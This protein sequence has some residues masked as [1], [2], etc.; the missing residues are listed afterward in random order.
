MDLNKVQTFH[1]IQMVVPQVSSNSHLIV[2]LKI[3]TAATEARDQEIIIVD[4][5]ESMEVEEA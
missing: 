3:F 1:K 5:R 2:V 4:L